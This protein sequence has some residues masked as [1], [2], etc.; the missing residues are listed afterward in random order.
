MVQL[1]AP[2]PV[3]VEIGH[4]LPG[5]AGPAGPAGADGPPGADGAAGPAGAAGAN[6][7]TVVLTLAAYLALDAPTQMNG[8]WYVI[9]K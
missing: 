6:A 7:Q 3:A 4:A 5:A 1:P 2:V 8:T 9:P